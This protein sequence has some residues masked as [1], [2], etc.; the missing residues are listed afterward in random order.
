MNQEMREQ[1]NDAQFEAVTSIE[2]PVLVI[3]GAGSGKTRVI[4]FRVR[5]LVEAAST[6]PR[7]CSLPSPGGPHSEMISRAAKSD[8]RCR[9]VEGGTFHSFANKVLRTYSDCF[10][11]PN[12]FTI[13]DEADAEEAIHRCAVRLGFYAHGEKASAKGDAQKDPQHGPQ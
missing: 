4:D 12:S 3:A 5:Y 9:G 2:G 7:S 11:L 8:P 10:G 6:P 1:L 13:Y